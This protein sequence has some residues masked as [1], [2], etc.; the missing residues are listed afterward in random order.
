[1]DSHT[2]ALRAVLDRGGLCEAHDRMLGRDVAR[3]TV[4][5]DHACDGGNVDDRAARLARIVGTV[6][7]VLV[8]STRQARAK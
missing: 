7:S 6:V 1:M 8:L 3:Q 4:Y 5:A 2:D